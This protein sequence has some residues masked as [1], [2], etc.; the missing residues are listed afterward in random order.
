MENKQLKNG[1]IAIMIIAGGI[2]WFSKNSDVRD[3]TIDVKANTEIKATSIQVGTFYDGED[4][5]SLSI[6]SGNS[7][8]CTW[9]YNGGS[10]VIPYIETTSAKSATE[11][12]VIHSDDFYDWKVSCKDDFGNS[13]VGVFPTE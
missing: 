7:S 9:N 11:K 4:G 8:I 12:H 2:Y 13:Y 5:Y 10:G 3:P 6:P 1:I